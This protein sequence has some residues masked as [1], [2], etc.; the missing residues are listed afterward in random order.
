MGNQLSDE[1]LNENNNILNKQNIK[2][3]EKGKESGSEINNLRSSFS[4][5]KGIKTDYSESNKETTKDMTIKSEDLSSVD[6]DKNSINHKIDNDNNGKIF[7]DKKIGTHF[8]WKEGGNVV[9]VTGNFSNWTQWF[10]MNKEGNNFELT[11]V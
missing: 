11:L 4:S 1:N 2:T 3:Q 5:Y 8:N 7:Q 6:L 10:I 9:Y